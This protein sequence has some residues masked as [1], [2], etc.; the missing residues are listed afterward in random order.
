VSHPIA[1]RPAQEPGTDRDRVRT[2]TSRFILPPDLLAQ[3]RR[4]LGILALVFGLL[5]P[6]FYPITL[7]SVG[8]FEPV[9]SIAVGATMVVSFALYFAIRS[10]RFGDA[11]VL[12]LGLVFEILLCLSASSFAEWDTYQ[13]TGGEPGLTFATVIIVLFPL[14]VPAPPWL[15]LVSSAIAASMAP[16]GLYVVYWFGA[17]D[18]PVPAEL[19]EVSIGPAACVILATMGSRVIHNIGAELARARQLGSYTLEEL[20]GRGG[21]GEVWRARHRMLSRPAAIKLIQPEALGEDPSAARSLLKRFELEAQTTARLRSPHTVELY[22]FG[23]SPEGTFYYVMELLD[24]VDLQGF[25]EQ[26]GALPARRAVFLL[27]QV[28]RSLHEAHHIGLVHRDIKPSNIPEAL[29]TLVLSCLEKDPDKRPQTAGQLSE[30]LGAIAFDPPWTGADAR[31][32]WD[33]TY[34]EVART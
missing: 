3:A 4:R 14:I 15:T 27:R 33:R 12:H 13:Q 23:T 6:L 19:I 18:R 29:D 21:M 28:C 24:G 30:R 34:P 32:W 8:E 11:T 31:R 25:V 5:P 2:W 1:I 26:H 17:I 10:R 7:F 20:L 16:F 22:D 9:T